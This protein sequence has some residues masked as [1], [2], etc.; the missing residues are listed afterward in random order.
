MG[1]NF[2][3]ILHGDCL[4][5]MQ[6]LPAESYDS[7]VTDP[8]YGLSFMG[9]HWDNGVPSVDYWREA[10]RVLKPGAHLLAFGGTRT[11]HRLACA[12]ED[13][14][15][16]I[17]DQM[18][19]LYGSG[20][21]KSMNVS[22][23]IDKM[24]GAQREVVGLREAFAKRANTV[25]SNRDK[26]G[27]F[28]DES[29]PMGQITAPATHEAKEWDGWGTALKP[30]NEPIVVA[31][32]PLS[33]KTVALNVLKWGTG[34]LN[35]DRCRI[36][37]ETVKISQGDGFGTEGIYGTG[38]NTVSKGS[39]HQGR[40]PS[41]TILGHSPHCTDDQCDIECAIAMLDEQSGVLSS[42]GPSIN[43]HKYKDRYHHN[44]DKQ[45]LNTHGK[46]NKKELIGYPGKGGASRFFLRIKHD[47]D[48][49]C[50]HGNIRGDVTFAG[51]K[52]VNKNENLSTDGFGSKQ[53]DQYL[54]GT[55]STTEM[56]THSIMSFPILN[57]ST[58]TFIGTCTIETAKTINSSMASS[59]ESVSVV[60]STEMLVTFQNGGQEPITG[61]VNLALEST[62][63]NGEK[64]TGTNGMPISAPIEHPKRFLYC[65]KASK[66]ERNAGLDKPSSHPTV[67]PI[68]L[69]RYLCRLVTQ[70]GGTVL[71]PFCGSGSTGV[72]ALQEGF[73][74]LGIEKEE[75]YAEI[76][77]RRL[78]KACS[79]QPQSN[80]P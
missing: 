66:S 53:M 41:N 63:E 10:Y 80:H 46:Y 13:A 7:C 54:M 4:D 3:F 17:R 70:P 36:G 22:K 61:I 19:W 25:P 21:P 75:E 23:A 77:R 57:A 72:A 18:Q 29:Y 15:F 64:R 14:G 33:E 20:F 55:I 38:V 62:C 73:Q 45:G 34:A 78:Q 2:E 65:A 67:K 49:T 28:A 32:K 1:G 12:I 35:I 47:N 48:E 27:K 8:P 6:D 52:T 11:Y 16:E 43:T 42:G 5:I 37:T 69:M 39:E 50:G 24:H 58:K 56:G 59:I 30:S 9:K 40:W 44:A 26:M 68:K 76:A 79:S 31:R 51:K 60:S 71:D 74:F